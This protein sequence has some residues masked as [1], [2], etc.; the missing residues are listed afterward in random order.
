MESIKTLG[1]LCCVSDFPKVFYALGISNYR[2]S[3]LNTDTHCEEST[4][5]Q[6]EVLIKLRNSSEF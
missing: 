5:A 2:T 4:L 3:E 1:F 6:W